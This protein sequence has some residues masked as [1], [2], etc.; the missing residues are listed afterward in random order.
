MKN[1]VLVVAMLCG[2][3]GCSNKPS[4][5]SVCKELE[6]AGVGKNCHNAT[7]RGLLGR[8]ARDAV[9]IDLPNGKTGGVLSFDDTDA[10]EATVSAYAKA[11]IFMGRHRYGNAKALIFVNLDSESDDG[12][13]NK[14]KRV[15]DEL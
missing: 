2:L 12:A 9:V 8:A 4:A 10:F 11:S 6:A 5:M 15:V 7:K 14:A 1:V 3:L 13:G